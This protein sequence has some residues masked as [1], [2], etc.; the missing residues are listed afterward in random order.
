MVSWRPLKTLLPPAR[1]VLIFC[2]AGL[3]FLMPWARRTLGAY[4][5]PRRPA[6]SSRLINAFTGKAR[7]LAPAMSGYA[8]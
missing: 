8:T 6:F 5:I 1:M 2:I 3:L 7:F 4:R